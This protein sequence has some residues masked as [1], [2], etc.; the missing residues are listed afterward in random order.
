MYNFNKYS[1]NE[2]QEQAELVSNTSDIS[3]ADHLHSYIVL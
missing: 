1:N 2:Q 3:I